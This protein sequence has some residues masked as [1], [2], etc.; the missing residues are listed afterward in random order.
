MWHIHGRHSVSDRSYVIIEEFPCASK[1]NS[2]VCISTHPGLGPLILTP[3]SQG[4][5]GNVGHG[6]SKALD[7]TKE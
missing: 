4:L 1:L 6:F 3:M 5:L 7:E 2:F